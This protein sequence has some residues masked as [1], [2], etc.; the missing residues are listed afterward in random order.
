M[1]QDWNLG[2]LRLPHVLIADCVRVQ[3]QT[4]SAALSPLFV[5]HFTCREIV[6]QRVHARRPYHLIAKQPARAVHKGRKT[7]TLTQSLIQLARE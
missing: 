5:S 2:P 7:E 6:T 1:E 4:I 3:T